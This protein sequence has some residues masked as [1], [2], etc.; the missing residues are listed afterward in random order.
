MRVKL[1][2]M[3]KYIARVEKQYEVG[4]NTKSKKHGLIYM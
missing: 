4:Y 2:I 1:V 3:E